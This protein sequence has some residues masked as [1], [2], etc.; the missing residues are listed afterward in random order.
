ML[1]GNCAT[2]T[3]FDCMTQVRKGSRAMPITRKSLATVATVVLGGLSLSA[4]ATTDYVDEQ[5]AAVNTRIDGV[6]AKAGAAAAQAQAAQTEAQN[7]NR[8]LDQLTGRVDRLEQQATV[9]RQP[10][11]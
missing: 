2:P 6:D 7:A 4:C 5:I 8:R 10:R 1:N 11:N 3:G 9:Q